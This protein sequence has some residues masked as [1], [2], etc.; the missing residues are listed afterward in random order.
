[1]NEKKSERITT[2]F[3]PNERERIEKMASENNMTLSEYVRQRLL[4]D[5]VIK[6]END[7]EKILRCLSICTSFAQ[8]Y[9][10]NKFNDEQYKQYSEDLERIMIKNGVVPVKKIEDGTE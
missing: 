9:A 8:T 4:G 10:E 1:M 5:Y 3:T 2:K 6:E 7:S